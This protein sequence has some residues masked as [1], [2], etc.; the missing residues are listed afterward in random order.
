MGK[1]VCIKLHFSDF[2]RDTFR[3]R[4]G[5]GGG[6]LRDPWIRPDVL[7]CTVIWFISAA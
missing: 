3:L 2:E 1:F 7:W 4:G 5:G 6:G